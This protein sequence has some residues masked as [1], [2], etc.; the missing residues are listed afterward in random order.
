MN[1]YSIMT[2][3]PNAE[4]KDIHDRMPVI[5]HAD[6]YAD[7]LQPEQSVARFAELLLPSEDGRLTMY[8]VSKD[9]NN[10]RNNDERLMQRA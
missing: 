2:T 4:M 10:V 6:E 1:E 7:W 8:E 9:V 3:D 5:L